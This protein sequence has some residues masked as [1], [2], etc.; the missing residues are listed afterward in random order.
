MGEMRRDEMAE[1]EKERERE[2]MSLWYETKIGPTASLAGVC[3]TNEP[4]DGDNLVRRA[5][6]R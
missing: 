5:R 1:R 4:S 6:F 3:L 2:V